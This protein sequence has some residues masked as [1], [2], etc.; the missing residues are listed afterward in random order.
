MDGKL[1][2]HSKI[3]TDPVLADHLDF[4]IR[5]LESFEKQDQVE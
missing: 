4:A 3:P 2:I 1:P 5:D